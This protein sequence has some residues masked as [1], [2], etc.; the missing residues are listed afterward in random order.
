[1]VAGHESVAL[2]SLKPGALTVPLDLD[3][4]VAPFT[5]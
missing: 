4:L 2:A 5:A 3:A 1:M